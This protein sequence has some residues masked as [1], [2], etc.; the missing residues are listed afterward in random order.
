[1]ADEKSKHKEKPLISLTIGLGAIIVALIIGATT[2]FIS[3]EHDLLDY[4]FKL[5]GSLD[6]SESPI[7]ILAIDDQSDESTPAR[8]PWP[9]EYFAHVIENLNEAGVKAIGIDVIF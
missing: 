4:R 8:W 1:M 6:I 7:V 9:R 5:R 3:L 2:T